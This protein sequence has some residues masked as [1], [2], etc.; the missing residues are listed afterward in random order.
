MVTH[1]VGSPHRTEVRDTQ[2]SMSPM[3]PS[4]CTAEPSSLP[5]VFS[6]KRRN[7]KRNGMGSPPPEE[8][9]KLM[10]Q[11]RRLAKTKQN[12][13]IA[14][15]KQTQKNNQRESPPLIYY[16]FKS[17]SIRSHHIYSFLFYCS[18]L[19]FSFSNSFCSYF[20]YGSIL[21]LVDSGLSTSSELCYSGVSM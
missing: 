20:I 5:I 10:H 11:S 17:K 15:P 6:K 9:A 18:V 12:R 13:P 1:R 14:K 21:G 3:W 4:T 19:L 16:F 7:F 2:S 8:G